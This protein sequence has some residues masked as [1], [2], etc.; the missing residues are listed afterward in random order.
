MP[1]QARFEAL[2]DAHLPALYRYACWLSGNAD[3]AQDLVQET[4][5]RAWRALDTLRE[6][7]AVKSWLT[8]TLRREHARTFERKRL[9]T[10]DL[11]GVGD[12]NKALWHE[13]RPELAEVRE[14]MSTLDPQYSEP[15]VL[16]V[17]MGYTTK[18]IAE[19]MQI[20]HS[21][22]LTRLH[23]ARKQLMEQLKVEQPA[24]GACPLAEKETG[25]R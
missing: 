3:Q 5:L 11:D 19:I 8:C 14:V 15:M 22:V 12:S 9:E 18:E 4:L 24:T 10:V 7:G 16:Q 21:A 23:R 25:Q 20:S 6:A 2:V 1:E 17:M 13:D